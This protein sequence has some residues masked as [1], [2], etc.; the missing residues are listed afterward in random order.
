MSDSWLDP[1]WDILALEQSPA[2]IGFDDSRV[3]LLIESELI[4]DWK[5]SLYQQV[6]EQGGEAPYFVYLFADTAYQHI[7]R[8]PVLL[9]VTHY[10]SLQKLWLTQ[11]EVLPAGCVLLT[12]DA[13]EVSNLVDV[14][15]HRLTVVKKDNPTF[16]RYYEPRML[17]PFLGVLSAEE[18][19]L[20]LPGVYSLCWYYQQ[21]LYAQWPAVQTKKVQLAPWSI[22]SQKLQK[23]T[24]IMTSIQS[25]EAGV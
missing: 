5:I 6:N 17:L 1:D 22:T 23:M 25:Y 7:E 12:D 10:P 21:W 3:Y 2:N 20:F 4:P 8:G 11:F 24:D 19:Q 14:L 18:R 9:D 13:V 16:L 15:R